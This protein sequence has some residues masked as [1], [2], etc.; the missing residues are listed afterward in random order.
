MA[1][2]RD[3]TRLCKAARTV[4]AVSL[5][6]ILCAAPSFPA[7]AFAE[8][9]VTVDAAG[10]AS[11]DAPSSFGNGEI[12]RLSEPESG[13][14]TS[15]VVADG[16]VTFNAP[17]AGSYVIEHTG[18][19]VS[20]RMAALAS[21][22]LFGFVK[23]RNKNVHV[24]RP[25]FD[26]SLVQLLYGTSFNPYAGDD[27]GTA[28]EPVTALVDFVSV[29]SNPTGSLELDAQTANGLLGFNPTSDNVDR[30]LSESTIDQRDFEPSHLL[31]EDRDAD[32]GVLE[33]SVLFSP[34]SDSLPASCNEQKGT[35]AQ[36]FNLVV[37]P[38]EDVLSQRLEAHSAYS[39]NSS[40]RDE[41]VRA[42]VEA[43]SLPH[44]VV[45]AELD[46]LCAFS[47]GEK[48]YTLNIEALS[49][50]K[51]KAGDSVRLRYLGGGGDENAPASALAERFQ[52]SVEG[53]DKALAVD[54][55]G[56][57]TFGLYG[58][59]IYALGSS[60]E[61][62]SIPL[63]GTPAPVDPDTPGE[64]P[65]EGE[66]DNGSQTPGD[67]TDSSGGRLV[68]N[69][70]STSYAHTSGSSVPQ[71]TST[72]AKTNSREAGTLS[73]S[74]PGMTIYNADGTKTTIPTNGA[75]GKD[76]KAT[77]VAGDYDEYAADGLDEGAGVSDNPF[78]NSDGSIDPTIPVGAVAAC[79][80]AFAGFRVRRQMVADRKEVQQ[81]MEEA[82]AEAEAEAEA[83]ASEGEGNMRA[84]RPET[85]EQRI[86]RHAGKGEGKPDVT[87]SDASS[88]AVALNL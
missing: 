29:G 80:V 41:A 55:D 26:S 81:L 70:G 63:L 79:A 17:S 66:G 30:A 60:E 71:V 11:I 20:Q 72:A 32:T 68:P 85:L 16:K 27:L 78:L 8:D 23:T 25:V 87:I 58:G 14:S 86:L 5:A 3:N 22:S 82:Q 61:V 18:S 62:D 75:N 34:E 56:F 49:D 21:T 37:N 83:Q 53:T 33:A 45:L 31:V 42:I 73:N 19:T 39:D 59:G 88:L 64:D 46:S 35:Q 40:A 57:V 54:A 84:K 43:E 36:A 10:A 4:L 15:A 2:I 38:S 24:L 74:S 65:N 48:V 28:D 44:T 9:A 76:T 13:F 51:V 67:N 6:V 50:G 47:T 69:G 7:S 12:V 52:E 1:A 77:G